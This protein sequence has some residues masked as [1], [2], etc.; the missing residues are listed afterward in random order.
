VT[1]ATHVVLPPA[2]SF[3]VRRPYRVARSASSAELRTTAQTYGSRF[4]LPSATRGAGA[5]SIHC[6]TTRRSNVTWPMRRA[7]ASLR[8][9]V[10]S[11]EQRRIEQQRPFVLPV[12]I[13]RLGIGPKIRPVCRIVPPAALF[14]FRAEDRRKQTPSLL[15]GFSWCRS[16]LVVMPASPFIGHRGPSR[17]RPEPRVSKWLRTTVTRSPPSTGRLR[18]NVLARRAQ[19]V[20]PGVN[21]RI[22]DCKPPPRRRV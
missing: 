7:A 21:L 10:A 4:A 15:P 22:S 18:R 12:H 8:S 13:D 1:S 9:L 11:R 3:G 19:R 5:C 14:G 2:P 20:P 17:D 6:S 16:F